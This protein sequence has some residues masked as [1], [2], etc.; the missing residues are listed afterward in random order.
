M[1]GN[2][3]GEWAMTVTKNWRITFRFDAGDAV[4][5]DL[6]DYH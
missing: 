2:R 5:V 1:E 4:K 3:K 6:E